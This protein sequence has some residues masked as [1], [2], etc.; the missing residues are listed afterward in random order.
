MIWG[1]ISCTHASLGNVSGSLDQGTR[2]F[3]A[4]EEYQVPPL[5]VESHGTVAPEGDPDAGDWA[6]IA[7]CT[8]W[9]TYTSIRIDHH[10]EGEMPPVGNL[11]V[12]TVLDDELTIPE[13]GL[14]PGTTV[15]VDFDTLPDAPPAGLVGLSRAFVLGPEGASFDPPAELVIHYTVEDLGGTADPETLR[16]YVYNLVSGEWDLLGGTVDTD[17]MT[18]T[19]D[20]YH[21]STVA[22][23]GNPLVPPAVG[24]IA[25]LPPLA[26]ASAQGAGAPAGGSGWSAGNYAALAGG[27]AAAL[28]ALGGAAWYAR[29]RRLR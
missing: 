13:G 11:T 3:D 8:D 23:F 9:G 17:L 18:L 21:F 12:T 6:C 20:L 15:T 28:V 5:S 14:E 10:S 26:A 29:R 24:G 16:V 4:V 1:E 7:G 27:L 22:V 19:V 2:S 25:E